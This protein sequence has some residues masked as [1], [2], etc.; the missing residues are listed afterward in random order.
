M[1]HIHEVH[2][3]QHGG[4]RV[5]EQRHRRR[6]TGY[7][8]LGPMAVGPCGVR[9]YGT[10]KSGDQKHFQIEQ[11]IDEFKHYRFG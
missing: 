5:P 4:H 8:Q 3:S 11:F 9:V 6:R 10:Q 7:A 2:L 1:Q